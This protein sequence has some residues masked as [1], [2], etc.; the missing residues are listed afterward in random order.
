MYSS[1]LSLTSAL[2]WRW[3]VSATPRPLY[4]RQ[5]PGTHIIGAW[6]G[7]RAGLDGGENL[8]THRD[9]IP[10][11]SS[12]YPVAIQTELT[13]YTQFICTIIFKYNYILI[14]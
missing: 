1:T 12:P 2:D 14:K 5:R 8:P 11:P 4:P 13:R 3:V 10:E 9:S 7:P 6:M